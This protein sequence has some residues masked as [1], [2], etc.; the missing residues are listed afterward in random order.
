MVHRTPEFS[1]QIHITFLPRQTTAKHG[2]TY[3]TQPAMP[4]F[5]L[6]IFSL[7]TFLALLLAWFAISSCL[8]DEIRAILSRRERQY[9]PPTTYSLQYYGRFGMAQPGTQ[10]GWEQFDMEMEDMQEFRRED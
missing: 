3:I 10:A 2:Y 7:A 6:L 9:I 4:T 1:P 5:L 8:G